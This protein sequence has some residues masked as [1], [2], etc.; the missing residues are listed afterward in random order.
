MGGLSK[1]AYQYASAAEKSGREA[2]VVDAGA[3]LFKGTRLDKGKEEEEKLTAAAI[4]DAYNVIGCRAVGVTARD[5]AAGVDYLLELRER[6]RFSWLSANLVRGRSLRP[7]FAPYTVIEVA[8][9]RVG[10]TGLTSPRLAPAALGGGRVSV[11]DWRQ[12]LRRVVEDLRDRADMII[13]LSNLPASENR[14]MAKEFPA[15]AMIIQAGVATVNS[16]PRLVEN[17][18]IFQTG[19]RGKYI[20]VMEVDWK[21]GGHWGEGVERKLRKAKAR[22]DRT[23]WQLGRYDI[24]DDP[25][26]ELADDPAALRRYQRLIVA[27]SRLEADVRALEQTAARER[28]LEERYGALSTFSNRFVPMR[29]NLPDDPAVASIIDELNGR[30]LEI[31]RRKA[32]ATAT[33]PSNNYIGWRRCAECHDGVARSWRQTPHASAYDTLVRAHRQFN[34]DCVPCHVTGDFSGQAVKALQV[35]AERRQ[36]GCESCHGPGRK[37]AGDPSRYKVVAHPLERVCLGCH[38]PEHDTDFDFDRDVRLVHPLG[39]EGG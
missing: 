10:V 5:L 27:R 31:G 29:A 25:A 6:S 1:K 11:I 14:A 19:S 8:G 13:V 22:L 3:L 24:Y 23:L 39:R 21:A 15:V 36:V 35:P 16:A 20:G 18:L 17:T 9:T 37:H 38:T 34:L 30:L 4:V 26:R 28:G 7:L 2:L 33:G 12:A 32:A